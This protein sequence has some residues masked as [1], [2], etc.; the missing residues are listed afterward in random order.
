MIRNDAFV[1]IYTAGAAHGDYGPYQYPQSA[2]ATLEFVAP[3]KEGKYEMRLYN[4]D[5]VYTDAT[6]EMKV[7]FTVGKTP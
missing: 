4:R 2:T 7:P 3:Q 5:Y 1:A 6:F